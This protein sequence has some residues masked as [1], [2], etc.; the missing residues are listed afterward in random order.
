MPG[1]AATAV[2][3]VHF[4]FVQRGLQ[5]VHVAGEIL[6]QVDRDIEADD[7]GLVFVGQNLAKKRA[8]NFLLHVD[9]VALAAAGVDHDA[10]A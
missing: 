4:G 9:D 1:N 7:E 5:A 8:A 3:D 10:D 6:Q 2:V